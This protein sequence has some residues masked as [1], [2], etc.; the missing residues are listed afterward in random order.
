MWKQMKT[1]KKTSK[2]EKYTIQNKNSLH[3][4]NSRLETV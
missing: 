3:E 1:I 4:V 2:A